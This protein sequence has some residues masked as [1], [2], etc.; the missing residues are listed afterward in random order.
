M[1]DGHVAYDQATQ[2][3][4]ADNGFTPCVQIQHTA[5][6]ETT[7]N[8]SQLYHIISD[9]LG[10]PKELLTDQGDIAWQRQHSTWG[11][12]R[13]LSNHYLKAANDDI[14]CPLVFQG[15]FADEESGLHYNRY[16][17]YDPDTAQYLSPDPLGLDGGFYPQAYVHNPN[18][19]VDPLGL[20]NYKKDKNVTKGAGK[21][22]K[23]PK[24]KAAAARGREAHKEFAERVKQKPGWKSEKTITG[25]KGEK[26]RPDALTPSGRPVE[27][28][29]N[30][31]S[32]RKQGARQIKKYKEATGTNGRVVYYDP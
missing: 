29:P 7:S 21:G 12:T 24:V 19:W 10:T 27:L 9:H 13:W 2:W 30:T 20:A 23:N 15:Q 31:P 26:L 11:D 18:G 5:T 8:T 22:M 16:R 4:Y 1:A 14:Y 32:G 25:P 17:Y 3:I 6:D 28:K